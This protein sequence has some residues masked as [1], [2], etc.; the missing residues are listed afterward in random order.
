M[1]QRIKLTIITALVA[2]FISS[3]GGGSSSSSSGGT[4][5][6]AVYTASREHV[7]NQLIPLTDTFV[8]QAT[9]LATAADNFCTTIDETNLGEVQQAWRNLSET[10]FR[11]AAYNFGPMDVDLIFP[12]FS[13]IDSFRVN[14]VNYT[15][16]VRN[17]I[18]NQIAGADTLDSAFFDALP[19]TN[20]G[21]LAL[22]ILSFETSDVGHSTVAGNIVSD[23][24]LNARKCE[25]LAGMA[26][27]LIKHATVIQNGWQ[28]DFNSTGTPYRTLFVDRNLDDGAD[29]VATLIVAVQFYIDYLHKRSVVTLTAL[30]SE[31]NWDNMSRAIDEVEVLLNGTTDTTVSFFSLMESA[32]FQAEIATVEGNI[33]AVRAAITAQDNALLEPALIA[34]DGNFKREILQGI[35]VDPGI[36]FTDGD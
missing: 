31:H 36:N 19:F 26:A 24:Q 13:F 6:D 33:A 34:L 27:Q 3:C 15:G 21:L 11:L 14:G 1:N 5:E 32:G 16:T 28:V 4:R 18:S 2:F 17:L 20:V 35:N 9:A 25:I 10:W 7:D 23:Y 8:T 29:P 12:T 22:E 30:L